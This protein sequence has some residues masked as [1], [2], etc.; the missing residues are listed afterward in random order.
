MSNNT[1]LNGSFSTTTSVPSYIFGNCLTSVALSTK[2][3][4][5]NNPYIYLPS[6]AHNT[7]F[8]SIFIE[9]IKTKTSIIFRYLDSN[10][11]SIS[12]FDHIDSHKTKTYKKFKDKVKGIMK[13]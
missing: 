7:L 2:P 9:T 5:T 8:N 13:R 10:N 1:S 3:Y 12:V 6:S 4:S 11:R